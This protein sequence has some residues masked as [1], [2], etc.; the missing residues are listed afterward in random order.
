VI[1]E[2]FCLTCDS[3]FDSNCRTIPDLTMSTQCGTGVKLNRMG[4]FRFDDSGS[5]VKRGCIE[6]LH[7]GEIE[8]CR[9]E[10]S[11]CKTCIGN[12][13]NLKAKFQSCHVCNSDTDFNCVSLRNP[14]P[15]RTCRSYTDECKTVT[16]IGGRTERGCADELT[17][18][19]QVITEECAD[20][21]C[22]SRDFPPNRIFCHQC[23]GSQ[24]S[25]SLSSNTEFLDPCRSFVDNEQ[26]FA[27]VD[28]T[29]EMQRGCSSDQTVNRNACTQAGE[30]CVL[31]NG[32]ACNNRPAITQSTTSC[33]QCQNNEGCAWGHAAVDA[34]N[35]ST[36]VIFPNVESCFTFSH[37]NFTVTRGC[38]L[39]TDL[40][41]TVNQRCMTCS[42]TGC[43]TQNVISQTCKVCRSDTSGQESCGQENVEGFD[44]NC[45]LNVKYENR[46]CYSK[47]EDGVVSR[48]CAVSLTS[49]EIAE[50]VDEENEQCNY[51]NESICN[52]EL[53]SHA[54]SLKSVFSIIFTVLIAVTMIW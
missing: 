20:D 15:T 35:C 53:P 12:N 39:E 52:I 37:E 2:E 22:N 51:C 36:N 30:R 47:I 14:L 50:C 21:N 1:E 19:G 26:C 9:R 49:S 28:E 34:S 24:C 17:I 11:E 32:S 3:D 13:C 10:G 18:S 54:A 42:G 44:Q 45:G 31:C 5:I 41:S 25:T 38:T 43:N 27:F 46:G 8:M 40:C 33:I 4:C 48:G 7:P 6:E 29:R 16:V 23:T